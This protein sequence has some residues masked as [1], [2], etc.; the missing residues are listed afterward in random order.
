MSAEFRN[1]LASIK[2]IQPVVDERLDLIGDYI[3]QASHQQAAQ[4]AQ[5]LPRQGKI[6]QAEY[7]E[8][9]F[10]LIRN[11][12]GNDKSRQKL[13]PFQAESMANP[14]DEIQDVADANLDTF[15]RTEQ[16]G[17]DV[18]QMGANGASVREPKARRKL[19]NNEPAMLKNSR[20]L[21]LSP[22]SYQQPIE[23]AAKKESLLSSMSDVY[24]VGRWQF[25]C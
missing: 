10:E 21:V 14:Y 9:P 3:K 13:L 23:S 20:N 18:T 8:N 2:A 5:N 25:D 11:D 1:L 15:K 17:T 4:R 22:K 24:F 19:T 6:G 7:Y 16:K 12:A